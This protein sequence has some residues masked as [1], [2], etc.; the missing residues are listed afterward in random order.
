MSRASYNSPRLAAGRCLYPGGHDHRGGAG[1]VRLPGIDARTHGGPGRRGGTGRGEHRLHQRRRQAAWQLLAAITESGTGDPE[2]CRHKCP[3]PWDRRATPTVP[4]RPG[5]YW[6]PTGPMGRKSALGS[7]RGAPK[8]FFS[9]S[10]STAPRPIP[11][12][13]RD[14]QGHRAR[15]Y[16]YT[17][18]TR[19]GRAAATGRPGARAETVPD[20]NLGRRRLLV[21]VR[22]DLRR[23]TLITDLGWSWDEAEQWL[24]Q[25]GI[26]DALLMPARPSRPVGLTAPCGARRN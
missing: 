5:S 3:H 18:P 22:L 4:L 19:P 24:A 10:C 9:P 21:P 23:R 7:T 14:A 17:S 11:P 1:V 13:G 15:Y 12:R 20:L 8:L 25:Q 6:R 16:R 26:V 2:C